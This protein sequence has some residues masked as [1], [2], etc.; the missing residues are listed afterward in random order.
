MSSSKNNDQQ[1]PWAW[2]KKINSLVNESKSQYMYQNPSLPVEILPW[3]FLSD[4]ESAQNTKLL[5]SLGVTHVLSLN[6]T[7]AHRCRW[8]TELYHTAGIIHKRI[9]AVDEEGYE[10]IHDHWDECYDFLEQ[11][12]LSEYFKIVLHC[13]SGI[14][15]SG[16]IACAA[17]MIF[18]QVTVVQ[19]VERCLEKRKTLLWNKSFQRQL[20]SLAAQHDLLGSKPDEFDNSPIVEEV[21]PPPPIIAA[22][23]RLL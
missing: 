17:M 3:L 13:V 8:S 12:R 1:S 20:C 18:E 2:I 16:V 5:K 22:F 15:R 9:H 6:G 10:M 23:D 11:V 4:E 7:T 21:L 14:N 19:A